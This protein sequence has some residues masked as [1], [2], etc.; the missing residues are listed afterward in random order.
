MS[1]P[2]NNSEPIEAFIR[3][4]TD[5]QA[6]LRGYCHASL[7][8]NDEAKE[9]MQRTNITLWKKCGQWNPETPFLPWAITVA[10]FEVLGV[11]RDRQRLQAR[12][13]FDPDVVEM[14]ADEASPAAGETSARG[15]ILERCL[16]KLSEANRQTLGD[17][18]VRG[19]TV[20]D[21]AESTE[22]NAGAVKV[23]LLRL[24]GKLR[25]CIEAHQTR[26]GA[27]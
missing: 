12:F 10:K 25:E 5:S 26:G 13:V 27:A 23:I 7:G 18:Y 15:E 8:Q 20:K 6:A 11:V 17:F 16:A 1:L 4:L 14:M 22:K 2:T 21:L 24:R 9:A 3:A 19:R